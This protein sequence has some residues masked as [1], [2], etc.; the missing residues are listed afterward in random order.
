MELK[1]TTESVIR[2]DYGDLD[3]FLTE[4]FGFNE[5]YKILAAEEL[6]ND[7]VKDIEVRKEEFSEWDQKELDEIL[8]TKKWKLYHTWL[9]LC[10]LCNLGEIPEGNYLIDVCW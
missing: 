1:Y 6:S 2:V 5:P 3:V 4:K 10:H 9:L 7:S 8:A